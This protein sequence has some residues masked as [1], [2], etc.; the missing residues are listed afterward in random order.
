M[1]SNGERVIFGELVERRGDFDAN[2]VVVVFRVAPCAQASCPQ[3][4]KYR[5]YE[6]A[7]G[8]R[9]DRLELL[10][11]AMMQIVVVESAAS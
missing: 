1:I 4:Q 3:A 11:G 2:A 5:T 10:L 9:I 6:L 8:G 7:K